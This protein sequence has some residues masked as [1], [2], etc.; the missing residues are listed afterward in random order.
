M[1]IEKLYE[2]ATGQPPFPYQRA[3]AT[4]DEL[5][6][7]LAVPTGTGKTATVV[8]GWLWRRRF[9][10]PEQRSATPRRL[11]FCLPMRTLVDQTEHVTRQW[12][13]R[14]GLGAEVGVHSLQGGAVDATFDDGPE[15][16]AVLVGTQ[17]QLLSRALN[18]GFGMS[19]FRWP[20]HFAWLHSDA[21]WVMDEVQLMGV[22]V[23]TAAQLQA[24][25]DQL[26]SAFPS[27]T[28]WMSATLPESKLRTVDFTRTL[29]QLTLGPD[30]RANPV[31]ARRLAARKSLER[32]GSAFDS[33]NATALAAEV[34]AAHERGT[35]TLVVVNRVARAQALAAALRT[36]AKRSG[37]PLDV[38]LVH[39][40]FRPADRRAMEDGVLQRGFDGV[41]VATQ[42]IEAGVD[43]SA[44][45]LFTELAPWSSLVQRFGR[46]NRSGEFE[47]SRV[48]WLDVPD[49]EAA[50]YT[51]DE[52]RLA[53]ER[54][55][56]CEEVG[57]ASLPSF[58]DDA[59]PALPVLRKRD[60]LEL[61][62]TSTD[63]AGC[64][65]DISRFVRSSEADRDVQ[66][67]WRA[68]DGEVPS[69][70]APALARDELCRVRLWD[71]QKLLKSEDAWRWD[72]LEGR[73]VRVDAKRL[74]P[75]MVL[76][77]PA[78]VGGYSEELGF[79]ADPRDRPR[80][81][82][83]RGDPSDHDE[84]D[85]LAQG[86]ARYVTLTEHSSD[87]AEELAGLARVL[88]DDQ[89]WPLLERAA[90]AHDL[91]KAH[92]AFQAMLV[93]ALA[94]DDPARS[95]GPWAKSDGKGGGSHVRR[96][97]RHELA[98]ALARMADGAADLEVYLVAAHHGKVRVSLRP[99]PDERAPAG[100]RFALG[101]W[102][103][104]ELPATDLG[105]G[106]ATRPVRLSLETMELGDG[107][108]GPSWSA[109]MTRLRD[110]YGPFRLAYWEALVRV[111]DWRATRRHVAEGPSARAV[112]GGSHE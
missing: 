44:K 51:P 82:E 65:V 68:W 79:T 96:Y 24:F 104:D 92:P 27:R 95:G 89:P 58:T 14:L 100:V 99:R 30:D 16:D 72:S 28:L 2:R 63:L 50:P 49:D 31:L 22:G 91:G 109:R 12:V 70:E 26:G 80:P 9:G 52:L 20:V 57:P 84:S 61:F 17:D 69:P 18:R 1:E 41:L 11:V 56:S 40:R 4:R 3:F 73:W 54:L 85:R 88:G 105:A 5:P 106:L 8:L 98:S 38:R 29:S 37:A 21:L 83:V 25:R 111:A 103:G 66:L 39:G 33:K 19:R 76:L 64:D 74:V 48:V 107:S 71:A 62:D 60:L 23:S 46:C 108:Q 78:S 94:E 75:G 35:L 42:A 13:E 112:A 102:E 32:A 45:A 53:R 110:T 36:H 43:I 93:A 81:V 86:A 7:V 97:F 59:T 55:G 10:S 47:R 67:A 34:F 101:V 87:A 90:R 77:V 15:R 6:D